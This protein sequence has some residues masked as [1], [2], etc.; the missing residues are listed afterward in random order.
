MQESFHWGPLKDKIY[1]VS[2]PLL[3]NHPS[4]LNLPKIDFPLAFITMPFKLLNDH[5][6]FMQRSVF[7]GEV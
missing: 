2:L 7:T 1:H 4:A 5:S 6:R 3:I